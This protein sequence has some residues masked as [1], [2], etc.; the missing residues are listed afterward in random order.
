MASEKS[1]PE[2]KELVRLLKPFYEM[3][4]DSE[5]Q[6]VKDLLSKDQRSGFVCILCI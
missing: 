3:Q 1:T 6:L 2:P 5:E 4:K